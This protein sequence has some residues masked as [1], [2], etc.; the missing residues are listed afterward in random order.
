MVAVYLLVLVFISYI[1]TE[2]IFEKVGFYFGIGYSVIEIIFASVLLAAVKR[3]ARSYDDALEY[4]RKKL[5]L[6]PNE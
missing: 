4:G 5:L 2:K 6:I 1:S 3:M